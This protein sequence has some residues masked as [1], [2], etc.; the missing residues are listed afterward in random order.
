[1]IDAFASKLMEEYV[2]YIKVGKILQGTKVQ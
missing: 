2:L 1:M